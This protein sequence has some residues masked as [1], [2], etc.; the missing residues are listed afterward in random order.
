M[1]DEKTFWNQD[2]FLLILTTSRIS[3]E[4]Q[5]VELRLSTR[6]SCLIRDAPYA[7]VAVQSPTRQ[8]PWVF[9]IDV[10]QTVECPSSYRNRSESTCR[11]LAALPVAVFS[12]RTVMIPDPQSRHPSG[13]T[14]GPVSHFPACRDFR[15]AYK[16]PTKSGIGSAASPLNFSSPFF[17]QV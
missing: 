1:T 9:P 5:Y 11:R 10:W 6:P 3:Y 17:R 8:T 7:T 15:H 13:Y 14:A 16:L 4:T 2:R 12:R